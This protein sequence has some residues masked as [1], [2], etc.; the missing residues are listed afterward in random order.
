MQYF[1]KCKGLL[2]FPALRYNSSY[3]YLNSH[4]LNDVRNESVQVLRNKTSQKR[5]VEFPGEERGRGRIRSNYISAESTITYN[6]QSYAALD[7]WSP[8]DSLTEGCQSSPL[9]LPSG[10]SIA[11]NNAASIAVIAMYPWGTDLMVLADGS[12]FYTVNSRYSGQAGQPK[13][14][15]CCAQGPTPLLQTTDQYGNA[16]YE[17]TACARRI[18]IAACP[19][20]S[21]VQGREEREREGERERGRAR[22]GE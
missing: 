22:V 19:A 11:Q 5:M 2:V 4:G 7:G 6:G 17:V 8:S 18:L 12:Q 3:V 1:L 14:W 21:F 10:W 16:Q 15:Y 9:N 13:T 20:G